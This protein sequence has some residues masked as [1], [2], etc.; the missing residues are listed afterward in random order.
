MSTLERDIAAIRADFPILQTT[1]RGHPLVYLDNAAT[2]QKPQA[3][4]D[5]LTQYYQTSNANIHRGLHF[6]AETAT[7]AYEAVR[8]QVQQFIHAPSPREIIFTRNATEALNLV[9]HSYGRTH[10]EAGDEI[11]LTEMEHH[12]NLI[13]W[14]LLAQERGAVLRFVPVT[15]SGGLQIEH[16]DRLLTP[17]TKI[18]AFSMLSNVL[19]IA[20]PVAEWCR[21]AHAVGAVSV[22]DG[23]QGV[24]HGPTD[25]QALDCDFLAFSAHKMCGPT[26]VGVL[27]GKSALLEAMPPFLGGGEMIATVDWTRATWADIPHKFEAGTPNIADVIAFGAAIHYLQ[28]LGMERIAAYE[29][30]LTHYAYEQLAAQP[31]VT[32]Y[33][34]PWRERQGSVLTFNVQDIHPHDLSQALDFEGIATRAGHHCTQPLMQRLGLMA[35]ARAS[36]SFY[37]TRAEV[38]RLVAALDVARKFFHRRTFNSL[39]C[40][41][42]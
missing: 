8:T 12:S 16:F 42:P 32:L 27:Y 17:R 34:P 19:G 18:V 40:R 37:N 21:R 22:V 25:V 3:V 5:A 14:Q 35:T 23:A 2:T 6:L 13:P 20:P 39:I 10:L 15:P 24:A 9:A 31:D 26:G 36:F 33:G 29:A 7:A 41:G 38:D 30:E 28:Q 4:L 1:V 11:L